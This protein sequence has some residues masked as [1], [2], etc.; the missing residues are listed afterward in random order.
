M[1]RKKYPQKD[2]ETLQAEAARNAF[3]A[4][5]WNADE[6]YE[7]GWING[8]K[9]LRKAASAP[10]GRTAVE[11]IRVLAQAVVDTHPIHSPSFDALRAVLGS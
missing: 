4:D 1:T 6:A 3:N 5:G 10:E 7:A 8:R 9:A 11:D 2:E